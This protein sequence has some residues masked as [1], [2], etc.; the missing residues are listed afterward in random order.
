MDPSSVTLKLWGIELAGNGTLGIAAV[1][2][3]VG[4]LL[5]A[6]YFKPKS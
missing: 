6:H 2:F 4:A 3:I 1:I 5:V